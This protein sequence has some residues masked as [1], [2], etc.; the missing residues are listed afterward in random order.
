MEVGDVRRVSGRPCFDIRT[1]A[2]SNSVFSKIYKVWDR[3]QTF[4]DRETLLPLRYEKRQR[5]GT[6]KKDILVKF[7]RE[8]R[9]ATYGDGVEAEF[10]EFAQDELSAFYA[11]RLLPL[12]VGK[13][14]FI[15]THTNKKNYP[16]QVII[17][18][19]ESVTVPAGTFDCYVIEP[20]VREGGIFAAKGKLTIWVTADDR[21]L[22]VLMKTKIVVGSISASLVNYRE[23][24]R[25]PRLAGS[26]SPSKSTPTSGDSDA[27]SVR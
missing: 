17:Q 27:Q 20:V 18:G 3:S 25:T 22:P 1:E 12:E 23:G 8:R 2:K 13:D 26:E 10:T 4:L 14:L 15:D 9:V 7:D 6:Y 21:K 16:L 19:R 24:E 5:E 11:M